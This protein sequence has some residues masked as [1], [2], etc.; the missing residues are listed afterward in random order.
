[1]VRKGL[2]VFPISMLL[3]LNLNLFAKTCSDG[4]MEACY[5]LASMYANGDGVRQDKHKAIKLYTEAC[6]GGYMTACIILGHMYYKGEGIPKNKQ[7]A[8]ELF[9]ISCDCGE[10]KGCKAY[11]ILSDEGI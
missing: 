5:N 8:K 9:S 6:D 11:K 3:L 1:M 10:P 2:Y 7:K 4:D